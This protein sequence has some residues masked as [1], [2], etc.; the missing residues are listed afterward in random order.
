MHKNDRGASMLRKRSRL[1]DFAGRSGKS[2]GSERSVSRSSREPPQHSRSDSSVRADTSVY[3]S[4]HQRDRRIGES[5]SD[6]RR[7]K[8]YDQR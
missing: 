2:L 4:A 8:F 5:N 1:N 3:V 7:K 6:S